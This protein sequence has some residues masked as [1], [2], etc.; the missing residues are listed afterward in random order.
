MI[1]QQVLVD[2]APVANEPIKGVNA[3]VEPREADPSLHDLVKTLALQTYGYAFLQDMHSKDAESHEEAEF[4]LLLGFA[5]GIAHGARH[6]QQR[7]ANPSTFS[8]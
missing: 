1:E 3:Y 4:Y 5:M 8:P 7:R 6:D 2:A